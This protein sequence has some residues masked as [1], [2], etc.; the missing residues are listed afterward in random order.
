MVSKSSGH[1]HESHASVFFLLFLLMN[2]NH[3]T[4]KDVAVLWSHL[5]GIQNVP[6]GRTNELKTKK[7]KNCVYIL[8]N[9]NCAVYSFETDHE[10]LL[11]DSS[12][13]QHFFPFLLCTFFR[14][15][16]LWYGA[17]ANYHVT[18]FSTS[19]TPPPCWKTTRASLLTCG[20]RPLN[21]GFA[22]VRK[23]C[24]MYGSPFLPEKEKQD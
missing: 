17:A 3:Y 11:I 8:I 20:V 22:I 15:S 24:P 9:T 16:L 4:V 23:F 5:T 19:W 18:A 6:E 13:Y 10:I 12:Q 21:V 1:S 2:R 14:I 7:K